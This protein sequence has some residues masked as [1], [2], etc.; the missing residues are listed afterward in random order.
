VEPYLH[1]PHT[2][3]WRGACLIKNKEIFAF[4]IWQCQYLDCIVS[5]GKIYELE[6]IWE[7]VAVAYSSFNPGFRAEIRTQH[8]LNTSLEYY[9]YSNLR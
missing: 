8:V 7:E 5:N 6:R 2:S 3:S 9:R 1:S 4:F